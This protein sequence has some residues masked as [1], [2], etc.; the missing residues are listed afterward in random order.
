MFQ[1]NPIGYFWKPWFYKHVERFLDYKQPK[2]EYIPLRHYYHRHTKSI[3]WMLQVQKQQYDQQGK[4]TI[5]TVFC[6]RI[7]FHLETTLPFDISLDGWYL[8]RFLC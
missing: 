3:F 2:V 4:K 7:L 5:L 6:C 8:Q 1:I